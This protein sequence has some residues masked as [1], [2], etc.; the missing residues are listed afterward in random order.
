MFFGS[1][2]YL[3]MENVGAEIGNENGGEMRTEETEEKRP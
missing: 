1:F 2:F 3:L